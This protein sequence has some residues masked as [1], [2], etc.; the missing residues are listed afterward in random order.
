MIITNDHTLILRILGRFEEFC[1]KSIEKQVMLYYNYSTKVITAADPGFSCEGGGWWSIEKGQ[2]LFFRL[3]MK[4]KGIWCFWGV[5][6][7]FWY[8][9]L[10]HSPFRAF[11]RSTGAPKPYTWVHPW[12]Q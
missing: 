5:R 7:Y 10:A 4:R 11:S 1:H 12:V 9:P 2:S 8:G 6:A 3:E